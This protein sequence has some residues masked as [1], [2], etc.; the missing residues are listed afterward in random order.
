VLAA[1][2]LGHRADGCSS[3]FLL[4]VVT[5]PVASPGLGVAPPRQQGLQLLL[6]QARQPTPWPVRSRCAAA[7][8]GAFGISWATFQ[9]RSRAVAVALGPRR[10]PVTPHRGY[11]RDELPFPVQGPVRA[12]RS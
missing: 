11:L 1:D 9:N 2:G 3:G 4:L 7:P 10:G 5:H 8:R 6:P 12:G